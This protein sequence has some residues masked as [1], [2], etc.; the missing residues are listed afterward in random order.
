[1][2]VILTIFINEEKSWGNDT[3]RGINEEEEKSIEVVECA[4]ERSNVRISLEDISEWHGVK[5][6]EQNAETPIE[7]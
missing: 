6:I 2:K 5:N 3:K 1:M 7:C 4:S